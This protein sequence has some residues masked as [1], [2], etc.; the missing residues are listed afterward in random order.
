MH[1]LRLLQVLGVNVL[2]LREP[3]RC[4]APCARLVR[5]LLQ[6]FR[7]L[8]VVSFA[9]TR[10]ALS[11]SN[12][13]GEFL[14]EELPMRLATNQQ[15]GRGQYVVCYLAARSVR[16]QSCESLLQASTRCRRVLPV[17]VRLLRHRNRRNSLLCSLALLGN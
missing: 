2:L 11:A 4:V 17:L 5:V 3:L 12:V 14:Q 1:L 6:Q 8:R 7:R 10:C 13:L 15:H 9:Q 16:W